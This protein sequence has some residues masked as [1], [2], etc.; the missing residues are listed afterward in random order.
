MTFWLQEHPG[1]Q[2]H[3]EYSLSWQEI[4]VWV[5]RSFPDGTKNLVTDM[6]L[7]EKPSTENSGERIDPALRLSVAEAQALFDSLWRA[8]LR[9]NDWG[10]QPTDVAGVKDEV[11]GAQKE[12]IND[13]REVVQDARTD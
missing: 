11:I 2:F 7:T 8:G 5:A 9:P 3:T 10:K 13:L 4:Q 1:L 6:T 12:H